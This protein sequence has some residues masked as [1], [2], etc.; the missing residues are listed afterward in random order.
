MKQ[1]LTKKFHLGSDLDSLLYD[2]K[3]GIQIKERLKVQRIFVKN[4]RLKFLGKLPILLFHPNFLSNLYA[5]PN[6]KNC[7][8]TILKNYISIE[9]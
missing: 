7:W 1:E 9:K 3:P 5:V 6:I 8:R 4:Q 2:L